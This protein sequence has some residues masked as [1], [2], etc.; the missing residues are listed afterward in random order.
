MTSGAIA[1][2]LFALGVGVN[3]V[4][5]RRGFMPLDHSIV[6]DGG[7]RLLSGQIPFRDFTAPSGIVP[8]A[9]QVPF[10]ALFG[11]T[12]FALCLHAS[13]VNGIFC[14]AVFALLRLCGS[15]RIEAAL[16]GG[17]TAFFF[18]PPAGTP[19]MD[20][21][22]FFFMTL[23]F[24]AV[25]WGTVAAGTAELVAW[26]T[27]PILFLLASVGMMVNALWT[28]PLNTGVTFGII[29][30]GLPVYFAWRAWAKKKPSHG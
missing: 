24:L 22:S 16:F 25:A 20:Q 28:D 13:I 14:A 19:F 30:V 1:I 6:F 2:A 29:L 5:G 8:A 27:V 11:V 18:Y 12:W 7:W 4:F 17:L 21:H 26:F 3:L 9:M 23:M 10:F 15:T